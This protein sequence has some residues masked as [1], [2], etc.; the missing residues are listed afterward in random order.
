M[1]AS[2]KSWSWQGQGWLAAGRKFCWPRM[3]HCH[4]E[5]ARSKQR[6]LMSR[7]STA[8]AGTPGGPSS[9]WSAARNCRWVSSETG[10]AGWPVS[11][12]IAPAARGF[13]GERGLATPAG[14]PNGLTAGGTEPRAAGRSSPKLQTSAEGPK[15][16][17]L[18]TS[19]AMTFTCLYLW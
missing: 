4:G 1:C 3:W 2:G 17:P 10:N 8:P 11:S 13:Q 12:S 18:W 6:F 9:S 7:A 14:Q 5:A 19:G 15:S 16:R